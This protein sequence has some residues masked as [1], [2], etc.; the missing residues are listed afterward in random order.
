[1][2]LIFCQG[3]PR[4]SILDFY[5][6]FYLQVFLAIFWRRSRRLNPKYFLWCYYQH[7]MQISSSYSTVIFIFVASFIG[8]NCS[9]CVYCFILAEHYFNF[10][11]IQ[12]FLMM[13]RWKSEWF[14]F[15]F[16]HIELNVKSCAC[17]II[18]LNIRIIIKSCLLAYNEQNTLK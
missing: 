10:T 8:K 12:R 7:N 3:N 1:M 9:V 16:L 6:E 5:V 17:F 18:L 2:E 13:L 14:S 11:N 4:S 15:I